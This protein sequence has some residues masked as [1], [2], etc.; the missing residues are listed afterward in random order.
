[1]SDIID[2]LPE[3]VLSKAFQGE[4]IDD[5]SIEERVVAVQSGLEEFE[6]N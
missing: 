4:L 6:P 2:V 5:E 1:M 3:S